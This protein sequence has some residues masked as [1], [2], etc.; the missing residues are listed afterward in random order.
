MQE[1]KKNT[2]KPLDITKVFVYGTLKSGYRLHSYMQRRALFSF[3][4]LASISVSNKL[5]LYVPNKD[6]KRAN[7][8]FPAIFRGGETGKIKGELYELKS[9]KGLELL[10]MVEGCP[11]LYKREVVDI[12]IGDKIEKAY[13]YISN[14][15]PRDYG[16][17]HAEEFT[18]TS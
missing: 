8:W 15:D 17:I 6:K 10:D 11:D 14:F 5:G 12:S 13:T 7:M 18:G 9:E 4:S 2:K 16:H 3:I 1:Q